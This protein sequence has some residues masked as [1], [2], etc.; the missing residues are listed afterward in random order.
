MLRLRTGYNR[1]GKGFQMKP[2]LVNTTPEGEALDYAFITQ[3]G[4]R[5]IQHLLDWQWEEF[6]TKGKTTGGNYIWV[7]TFEF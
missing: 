3:I 2:T 4:E 1:T 5:R 7:S 6:A